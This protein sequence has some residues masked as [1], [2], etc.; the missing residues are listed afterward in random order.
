MISDELLKTFIDYSKIGVAFGLTYENIIVVI[1]GSWL[2]GIVMLTFFNYFFD[3]DKKWG[4]LHFIEKSI[5][6]SLLGLSS[7]VV[8]YYFIGIIEVLFWLTDFKPNP[9]FRS[10]FLDVWFMLP[11]IYLFISYTIYKSKS[12]NFE[13]ILLKVIIQS[14]LLF[15]AFICI[16]FSLIALKLEYRFYAFLMLSFGVF[17]FWIISKLIN[18]KFYLNRIM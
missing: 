16:I 7:I 18:V 9:Y 6:S 11:F 12:H 10:E 2:V 1:I 3:N 5:I 17:I 8:S 13:K 4:K 14:L 15:V